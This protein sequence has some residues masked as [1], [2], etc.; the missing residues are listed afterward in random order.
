M[1]RLGHAAE[2]VAGAGCQGQAAEAKVVFRV[3]VA[4]VSS[5]AVLV[6]GDE[7]RHVGAHALVAKEVG[8]L[9]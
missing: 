3:K 1:D 5:E 7:V 9:S 4:L 8:V 2:A 6:G